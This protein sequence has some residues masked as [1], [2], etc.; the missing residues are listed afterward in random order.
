MQLRR[1]LCIL[2]C[3]LAAAGCYKYSAPPTD[4]PRAVI[5]DV[6]PAPEGAPPAP[7]PPAFTA[8]HTIAAAEDSSITFT[9]Y[10]K[11]A[12]EQ[13]GLFE[14]FSGE[15][16]FN[17][18]APEATQGEVRVD[19]GSVKADLRVITENL[20]GNPEEDKPAYF[21]P[22]RHG[23]AVF[24]LTALQPSGNGYTATGV[25]RLHGET[26]QVTVPV[27]LTADAGN[28]RITSEFLLDRRPFKLDYRLKGDRFI[29]D[30][31]LVKIDLLAK[32][33]P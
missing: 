12:G 24:T 11:I 27:A 5:A 16:A 22:E 17:P 3:C 15:I 30:E 20:R 18:A 6:P 8:T 33:K 2:A 14:K 26:R 13:S 29:H 23:E 19:T 21:D 9:G 25:L 32:P 28:V 1:N 31:V 10:G 4:L 7:A